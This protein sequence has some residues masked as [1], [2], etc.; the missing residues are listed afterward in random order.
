MFSFS[1]DVCPGVELLDHMVVLFLI[2]LRNLPTVFRSSCTNL[3]IYIPI[4]S[5]L[6]T[7]VFIS[8]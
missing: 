3:C 6:G 4:D 2:F 1:L 7:L 8:L 5:V